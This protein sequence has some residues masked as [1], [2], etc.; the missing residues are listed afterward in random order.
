MLLRRRC[1]LED[2]RFSKVLKER[3]DKE[4][5]ILC[6][7]IREKINLRSGIREKDIPRVPRVLKDLTPR[8]LKDL[9]VPRVLT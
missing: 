5:F 8:V 9:N 6:S 4:K 3:M 2:P 7:K 1:L